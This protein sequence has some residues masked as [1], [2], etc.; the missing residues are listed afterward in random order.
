MFFEIIHVIPD[1][2]ITPFNVNISHNIG[3]V[4]ITLAAVFVLRILQRLFISGVESHSLSDHSLP[5]NS[6]VS[7]PAHCVFRHIINYLLVPAPDNGLHVAKGAFSNPAG[8]C[9]FVFR[10]SCFATKPTRIGRAQ[11]LDRW[12]KSR[13]PE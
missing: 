2:I 11:R 13:F 10:H 7:V 6:I 9:L 3:V 4:K 8:R 12:I 5:S 1:L